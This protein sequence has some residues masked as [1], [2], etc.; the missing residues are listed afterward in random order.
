VQL[1]IKLINRLT[2]L[3]MIPV[4]LYNLYLLAAGRIPSS[5]GL[6]WVNGFMLVFD[7]VVLAGLIRMQ[8][9]AYLLSIA[10]FL[11][12]AATWIV[13]SVMLRAINLSTA[14][15]IGACLLGL[16]ILLC[17]YRELRNGQPV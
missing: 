16:P 2:V 9:T 1:F 4:V 11:L 10:G 14:V 12:M 15:G 13:N 17:A 8:K 7:V 6:W 5:A 3:V